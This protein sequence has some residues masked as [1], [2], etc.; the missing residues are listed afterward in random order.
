MTTFG[1]V[2]R[3]VMDG[4]ITRQEVAPSNQPGQ[5]K[6]TVTGEDVSVMM[7]LFDTSGLPPFPAMPAEARVALLIAKYAMFGLIPIVIPSVMIDVPIPTSE[8]P[9]QQG[10][11]LQYI[12]KSRTTPAGLRDAGAGASCASWGRNPRGRAA[13][14]ALQR[15]TAPSNVESRASLDGMAAERRTSSCT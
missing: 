7:D 8:I 13:A 2:P 12:K 10:N 6:L 14:G 1:V 9:S 3:V 5:S 4:I 11:D 15:F